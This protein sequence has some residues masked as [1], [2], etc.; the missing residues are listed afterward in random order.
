MQLRLWKIP[1]NRLSF[2]FVPLQTGADAKNFLSTCSHS[3]RPS[4]MATPN[5]MEAWLLH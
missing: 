2:L 1:K 5:D 4:D 3:V